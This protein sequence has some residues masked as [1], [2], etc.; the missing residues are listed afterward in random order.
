MEYTLPRDEPNLHDH[1]RRISVLESIHDEVV[2]PLIDEIKELRI[3]I[4]TLGDKFVWTIVG[5]TCVL[6]IAQ[7]IFH[8]TG[9]GK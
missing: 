6:I 9:M 2:K 7:W 5:A 3:Y 8:I 1:E 4:R